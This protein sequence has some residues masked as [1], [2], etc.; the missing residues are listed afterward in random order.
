MLAGKLPESFLAP[1]RCE[2]TSSFF[3]SGAS[4]GAHTW[5]RCSGGGCGEVEEGAGEGEEGE[6]ERARESCWKGEGE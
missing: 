6:P 5:F 3:W 4:A 1:P 2:F